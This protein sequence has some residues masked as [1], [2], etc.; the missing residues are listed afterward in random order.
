MLRTGTRLP[1]ALLLGCDRP[2]ALFNLLLT[3]GPIGIF[4]GNFSVLHELGMNL[5][6]SLKTASGC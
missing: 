2:L 1:V 3:Q 4:S 6:K 5:N